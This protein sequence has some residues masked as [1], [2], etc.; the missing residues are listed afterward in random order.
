MHNQT[1]E[2]HDA[3]QLERT[4]HKG[5]LSSN[6]RKNSEDDKKDLMLFTTNFMRLMSMIFHFYPYML[7]L[8]HI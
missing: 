7:S 4:S 1:Y 3:E 2:K 5:I 8:I 6:E